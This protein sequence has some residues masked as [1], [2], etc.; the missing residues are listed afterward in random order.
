ME[1]LDEGGKFCG[2]HGL[3]G[4]HANVCCSRSL[5]VTLLGQEQEAARLR[6]RGA[7]LRIEGSVARYESSADHQ[8]T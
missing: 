5:L 2:V 6:A 4:A 3:V 1:M 7:Q 8:V